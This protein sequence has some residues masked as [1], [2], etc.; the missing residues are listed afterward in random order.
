MAISD[1]DSMASSLKLQFFEP[2]S[3]WTESLPLGNGR[4]GA[5]VWGGV[6]SELLQLN[7]GS[8]WSGRPKDWNNPRAAEYLPQVRELVW[9]GKFAEATN[10]VQATMLGPDQGQ[11]YQPLGDIKLDF[12]ETHDKY[13]EGS[14]MRELNLDTAMVDVRYSINGVKFHRQVLTSY[15]DQVLAVSISA[16]ESAAVSCNIELSSQ[17]TFTTKITNSN[18]IVMQGNCP[19]YIPT[20]PNR[21]HLR[22]KKGNNVSPP[23]QEELCNP[24][25]A[26]GM[27]FAAVLEV[28]IGTSG[29]G[30]IEK[31]GDHMLMVEQADSIVVLLAASTSYDGA[32]TDPSVSSKDPLTESMT[33]LDSL[34][35]HPYSAI[36]D[37]HIKD[38][39]PLFQRVSIKLSGLGH[40]LGASTELSTKDRVK[41]FAENEDPDL[42]TLLFNFGR[43][44]LLACSRP[45]SVASNLQ[46]IWSADLNP[47]WGCTPHTNINLQMNYWLAEVCNLSECHQPLFDLI[48][49]LATN[50]STTAKINY[51]KNGWVAHH[52]V[53]VWGLT[54]P[55]NGIPKYAFW[56]M[57]GAWLCTHLWEHYQFTLDK[58]FLSDVAYPL[59]KGCAQFLL[60][61]LVD[62]PT[63][64]Y[65]VTNP[66]TSPEHEFTAPDGQ[67][68]SVSYAT[69]MDMAI[70]REVFSDVLS[71]A[72]VLQD[73]TDS[74][75][76]QN[77]KDASNRLFPPQ[78]GSDGLLME[79]ALPFEDP[80]V[81]H[82]HMSHLFGLYPGHSISLQ[83][84][85]ELCEAAVLSMI[86]RGVIGPG[87]STA[88]K[89]ALW[90]RLWKAE[91]AYEMVKQMF[92]LIDDSQTG[93]SFSGGGLYGNLF[94]AH[95][96]FQIDGN[97][98]MTAA[99]AEMLIQ[100][101]GNNVYVL[102]AVPEKWLNGEVLGLQAR[103][104]L[105]VSKL[106]WKQGKLQELDM[107]LSEEGV[108][109]LNRE[110]HVL[111]HYRD[112]TAKLQHVQPGI[113]YSFDGSLAPTS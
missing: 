26:D 16:S 72:E 108:D 107:E 71:T 7:E 92:F 31:V 30:R 75:F 110:G 5:M 36:A 18:R 69:A 10:M 99:I 102:P 112:A 55:S 24:V 103:G 27:S 57:G 34:V 48:S 61:W 46:G 1:K 25:A 79:W 32:F 109:N 14:Y 82:R 67:P 29:N 15:P 60:D 65:L 78:I 28:R 42:V 66:A 70:I 35:D 9:N 41:L 98:G 88:W 85:P 81:H 11:V 96:P 97:F 63:A 39:Q 12:G 91:K 8:M 111:L 83:K 23:Y 49:V 84:T 47:A 3:F 89:T 43:Y 21:A 113:I 6:R 94:C 52:I 64:S 40:Q 38:Y 105:K 54:A 101:D 44:L 4:L 17:L 95:P 77:V 22:K 93:E 2:S 104:G 86:K 13:D 45:G 76:V 33:V 19:G 20:A 73:T 74:E 87:W 68:A 53:D 62:D 58:K 100:S 90:A 37:R 51:N 59:L 56:P 106:K 50:G 80:E